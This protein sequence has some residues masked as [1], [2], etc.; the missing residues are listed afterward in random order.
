MPSRRALAAV[1]QEHLRPFSGWVR[2]SR[3]RDRA[4]RPMAS[5]SKALGPPWKPA[6]SLDPPGLLRLRLRRCEGRRGSDSHLA[7]GGAVRARRQCGVRGAGCRCARCRPRS[8]ARR[9]TKGARSSPT[10]WSRAGSCGKDSACVSK[11]RPARGDLG[12]QSGVSGTSARVPARVDEY[13][14]KD[15]KVPNQLAEVRRMAGTLLEGKGAFREPRGELARSTRGHL[16]GAHRSLDRLCWTTRPDAPVTASRLG[17]GRGFALEGDCI[18][19]GAGPERQP[20]RRVEP[21]HGTASTGTGT[22][23][24]TWYSPT[25]A[26]RPRMTR[27]LPLAVAIADDDFDGRVDGSG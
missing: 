7:R 27:P 12:V 16:C 23:A 6:A 17:L 13:T 3:R 11:P 14:A 25:V 1:S 18:R 10:A 20:R 19:C 9:A 24:T 22:A 21:E 26:C 4:H 2:R 8:T 15:A 5:R